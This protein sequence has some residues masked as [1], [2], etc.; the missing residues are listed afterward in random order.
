ML[1][2]RQPTR[3]RPPGSRGRKALDQLRSG[4]RSA[5]PTTHARPSI[6]EGSVSLWESG[7]EIGD[8]GEQE[9]VHR[10]AGKP[11]KRLHRVGEVHG[12]VEDG[13]AARAAGELD[14]A[15]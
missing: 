14:A 7:G 3:R 13:L 2:R 6:V 11:V 10:R 1:V 15:V 12:V 4:P 5:S 8:T 9:A